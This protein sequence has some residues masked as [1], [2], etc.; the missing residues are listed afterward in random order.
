MQSAA[1]VFVVA[2]MAAHRL[3]LVAQF[4][5]FQPRAELADLAVRGR[6]QAAQVLVV[7]QT[8]QA[9]LLGIVVAGQQATLAM[10]GMACKQVQAA[11]QTV[12]AVA[13]VAAAWATTSAVTVGA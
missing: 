1:P 4:Q 9:V 2:V 8:S 5:R 13:A 6:V 10:A 12:L 3:F 7:L 11:G